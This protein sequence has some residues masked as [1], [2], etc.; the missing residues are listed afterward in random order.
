MVTYSTVPPAPL[1]PDLIGSMIRPLLL[2]IT[3]TPV[4]L[5]FAMLIVPVNGWPLLQLAMIAA[6]VAPFGV[7]FG[8]DGLGGSNDRLKT[9]A[10]AGAGVA[11][12]NSTST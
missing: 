6:T 10:G 1:T 11:G 5:E 7:V 9:G 2:L 4:G 8:I 3:K 12:A